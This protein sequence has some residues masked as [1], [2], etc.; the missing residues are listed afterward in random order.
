M[1]IQE[2]IST[3][4]DSFI[5]IP[6]KDKDKAK[7]KLKEAMLDFAKTYQSEQSQLSKNDIINIAKD[8]D[9]AKYARGLSYEDFANEYFANKSKDVTVTT[10]GQNNR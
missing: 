10:R 5:D 1:T 9:E 3:Y 6:Y 7:R 8:Y 2:R 4:V